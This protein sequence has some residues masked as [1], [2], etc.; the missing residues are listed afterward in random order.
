[1]EIEEKCGPRWWEGRRRRGATRKE[2]R[3][4]MEDEWKMNMMTTAISGNFNYGDQS[5]RVGISIIG[6]YFWWAILILFNDFRFR[7]APTRSF[8]L[9]ATEKKRRVR[10]FV[11][12]TLSFSSFLHTVELFR[13]IKI[14]SSSINHRSNV[15]RNSVSQLHIMNHGKNCHLFLI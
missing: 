15:S 4:K 10:I 3:R 14:L 8:L 5:I 9:L 2:M 1:M 12:S 6:I 13:L 7:I 11:S